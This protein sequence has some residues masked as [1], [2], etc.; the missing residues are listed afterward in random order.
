MT[1][2]PRLSMPDEAF[3]TEQFQA[4]MAVIAAERARQWE[5]RRAHD[6]AEA[7]QRMADWLAH[8]NAC[9]ERAR[10]Y[11]AWASEYPSSHRLHVQNATYAAGQRQQKARA[12]RYFEQERSRL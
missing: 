4:G 2:S 9:D 1:P 3:A 6:E 11:E 7:R 12:M 5:E 10:M 8:A